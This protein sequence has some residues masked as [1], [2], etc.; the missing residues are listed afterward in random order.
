M[1]KKVEI[2]I[3][4]FQMFID[5]EGMWQKVKKLHMTYF[6]FFALCSFP[7]FSNFVWIGKFFTQTLKLPKEKFKK[8]YAFNFQFSSK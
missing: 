8:P 3:D 4:I 6:T 5:L 7:Q 2:H 1:T